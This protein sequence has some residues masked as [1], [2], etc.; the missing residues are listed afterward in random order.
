MKHMTIGKQRKDGKYPV[1]IFY[2]GEPNAFGGF[3]PGKVFN[4]LF[5][6]DKIEGYSL[7]SGDTLVNN[8]G[9]GFNF[10]RNLIE[11]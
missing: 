5:T 1:R 2:R 3:Y 4:K 11:N 8:S 7:Y 10:E 6:R 9:H